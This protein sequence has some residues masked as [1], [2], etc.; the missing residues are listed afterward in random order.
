MKRNHRERGKRNGDPETRRRRNHLESW[1]HC[2]GVVDEETQRFTHVSGFIVDEKKMII[3]NISFEGFD[4]FRFHL[5]MNGFEESILC[6]L[7][8]D[9]MTKNFGTKNESDV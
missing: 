5:R 8:E 7:E 3:W 9:K 4:Q 6:K 1:F 2:Q